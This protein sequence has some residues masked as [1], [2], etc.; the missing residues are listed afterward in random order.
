MNDVAQPERAFSSGV[1]AE[2]PWPGLVAFTEELQQFFY[3]RVEE[4]DELLRRVGRKNLTV[5]FGQSGLGKSSLLQAGLFPRLRA[6]G[7]LPVAIRLDHAVTAPPLS[8]QVI[9]AVTRAIIDSGGR[10]EATTAD[11]SETLWEHFHRRSLNLQTADGRQIR[12]VLVFDQFEELFAIGQAS[13]ATRSRAALFLTELA[14]LVENRAPEALER[15]L[16]DSPELVKQFIFDDRDYRILVCLREDYLAHLESLRQSMPSSTENRMRL[17]RMNGTRALEAVTSPGGRLIAAE[18][19]HQV[20]RFVAGGR[21]TEEGLEGLEVEPSLLSLVCRELNNRRLAMG[22][23]QITADL[24]AGNRERILQD[25]YER[26]VADQPA[27]VREFVEDELVTDSGLR[28]NIALERAAKSLAQ[29]GAAP[30]SIDELV[31]RRLLHLE[32]RLDIQR[33]ELTHDVLTSVVKKS[34]DERHQQEATLR[35]ERKAREDRERARV[36]RRRFGA[37]L[38][39]MAVALAIVSG[40]GVWSYRLYRISQDRFLEAQRQRLEAERQRDRA[41]KSE[42]A[43]SRARKEAEVVK[44]VFDDVTTPVTEQKVRHLAGL[45]PVHEELVSIR[46]KSLQLLAQKSPDDPTIEL[47]TARAQALLGMIS[48]HVGSFR[49]AEEHLTKALELYGQIAKAHPDVLDYR[50]GECRAL[51]ELGYLYREDARYPS[52]RHWYE[53]ALARLDAE[54]VKAPDDLEVA[55]ELGLCLIR[56]GGCLPTV[57]TKETREK[58]ATRA[59]GLFEELVNLKYREADSIGNLDVARY[60][61]LMARFD[62]KDQQALLKS[63]DAFAAIDAAAQKLEPTSPYLNGFTVFLHWDR[64][65]AYVKLG[66]LK[67]ALSESEAAVATAREI[68]K[69]SPELCSCGDLLADA[70]KRLA[71]NLRR[72]GR[73]ADARAAFEESI[74]VI[75]GLVRRY[76][77][78]ALHASQWV[79]FQN[80]LADF[81]ENGPKSQGEIQARQDLLRTLDQTVKR[82][83]ELAARF[84]DHNWLQVNFAKTLSVR[85]RYDTQA[86]QDESA[87]PYLLEGV[88]VY[89]TRILAENAE[90]GEDDVNAYLDQL[91]A[92]ASCADSLSKGDEIIR[93]SR[94]A[95]DVGSKTKDREALDWL[96]T[97]LSKAGKVQS[98]A[99]RYVEAV[100]AF[101]QAIEARR[102]TFEDA[103]WNWYAHY[104]L[105]GDYRELADT[106]RLMKDYRSEVLANREY[107]RLIIG[108]WWSAKVDEYLDASRPADQ[109]EA[110]RIRALIKTAIAPGMKRFTISADFGGIKY[111]FYIYITN[112]KWPKHPLEDQAR[113]LKEVRGGTIPQDVM[114]TFGRLSKLAHD[115][116]SSFVDVCISELGRARDGSG[117]EIENLGKSPDDT[118][119]SV[120]PDRSTADPLA[121]LQARL[122]EQKAKLARSPGNLATAI[123]AAQTYEEYGQRRLRAGQPRESA[124]ALRESV[125]LSER[126]AREQPSVP[127]HRERLAATLTWLGKAHVQ[128]KDLY[129]ASNSFLRRLDLLEQLQREQP[130]TSRRAA[131]AETHLMFGELAEVRGDR[132]EA[133]S[134]YA[135]ATEEESEKAATKVATLLR[136]T[137]DLPDLL[138]ANLKAIYQGLIKRGA[139]PSH[140]AFIGNFVDGVQNLF[141]LAR[142]Q[143]QAVHWHDLAATHEAKKQTDDYRNAL[144]KEYE[145]R[146][147]Q[148]KLDDTRDDIK[149]ARTDAAVRLAR[150]HLEAKQMTEAAVWTERAALLDHVASL[151]QFADWCEKGEVVKRDPEKATRYRY[152]GHR[153]PGSRAFNERRY[154]AAVAEWVISTASPLANAYDF[155]FLGRSYG[156]LNRWDEAVKAYTR[157]VELDLKGERAAG[158]VL[159]LLEALICAERPEQLLQFVQSIKAKGWELPKEGT[160]SAK[161]SSLYYGFQAIA[162]RMSGKDASGAERTMRE[163][164]G[165]PDFAIASWTWD[166][167]DKWLKTTKLAPEVKADV[168]EIVHELQ[169]TT[170]SLLKWADRYEKGTEGKVDVKKASRFRHLAHKKRGTQLF[171]ERRY[172]DALPDLKLVCDSAESNADDHNTLAMCYGKLGRWDDAIKSYTRSIEFDLNSE[173][174]TGVVLNLLE[175]LIC[176]ER[177]EQLLQFVQSIK[178]KGWELPKEGTPAAKYNA[179]YYGFQA[180]A[181][182]MTGKDASDAE[183][184]MRQFIGKPDY[185]MTGWT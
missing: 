93:L 18:V 8:Q 71:S 83:R 169:G 92:A 96:G 110:D 35:A 1:D 129:A 174:A 53:K 17:T 114:D 38:A 116:N 183:R 157:S 34:R 140:P 99:A 21:R 165:N 100:Q 16:D 10:S 155:E 115:N 49:T 3:G 122:V 160:P 26:C 177:P 91:Q 15:Q 136:A 119:S 68:V 179:F 176:V 130:S 106:Y 2:N 125:R 178:T 120:T 108:P 81:F 41:E 172:A 105:G 162:L 117:L 69:R 77:D 29:R 144:S 84:P 55:Y 40:F 72:V 4:A 33:V 22:L 150:S 113:W 98:A 173:A 79:K 151:L 158:V 56:L 111:A 76:P 86:K 97:I 107:L 121:G 87:L 103:P 141:K 163:F 62:G 171:G 148:M 175:A 11:S 152:F 13:E 74:Q 30:Q 52:A 166:E 27:A 54:R 57:A 138:P 43:A 109:A 9:A 102:P 24:V 88:E 7:Y 156:N 126:I 147:Q 145:A 47:K 184:M 82:G 167:L 132:A 182:R 153:I 181:L 94:L 170:D 85:G 101:R 134:W 37:V 149:A 50:L 67:E 90:S 12:P 161:N 25:F 65:A 168:E 142:L 45:S 39:A 63:L 127:E 139:Q 143:E 58:I 32:D 118:V 164:T 159:N 75:D 80:E 154:E 123:E 137:A 20:V 46:L 66:Q 44:E 104:N 70:L 6:E 78:R 128:L 23:P 95:L 146:E 28:E 135:R 124:D 59:A 185:K 36:Q 61:L 73:E 48:T 5:L 51:L 14:D 133:L 64:A 89:R 180:M 131:I 31:K 112:V 42:T 19:A 60:R